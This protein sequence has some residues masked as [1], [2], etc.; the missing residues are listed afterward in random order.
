MEEGVSKTAA[1]APKTGRE[2][3]WAERGGVTQNAVVI[4]EYEDKGVKAAGN[5]RGGGGV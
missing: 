3:F 4:A 1:R 2:T 5:A